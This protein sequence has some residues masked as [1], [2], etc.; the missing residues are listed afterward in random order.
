MTLE[1]KIENL[2]APVVESMGFDFWGCEYL[3]A[4]KHSTLCIFID[5]VGGINVDDCGDVSHQ[6]SAIMDVEDPITNAYMLEVSSP[7]INRPLFKPAQYA[8]NEGKTI[9]VR[10]SIP[11]LGRRNFKGVISQV[12]ESQ[13]SIEVDGETYEIPFNQVDK[14]NLEI[15]F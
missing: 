14:A 9:R 13:F 8:A 1:E 5:K 6:I 12:T 10:T 15:E 11:I 7:G 3:S 2:I 4:G